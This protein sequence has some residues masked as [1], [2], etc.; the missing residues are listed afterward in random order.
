MLGGLVRTHRGCSLRSHIAIPAVEVSCPDAVAATTAAQLCVALAPDCVG[1]SIHAISAPYVSSVLK[2]SSGD[3]R[4]HRFTLEMQSSL[5]P[6]GGNGLFGNG[7]S[8][9]AV[10]GIPRDRD[11]Q[12]TEHTIGA[13]TLEILKECRCC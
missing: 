1:L 13:S 4:Q 7:E 5:A 11:R 9:G 6:P 8:G 12:H 3:L 10:N 2:R